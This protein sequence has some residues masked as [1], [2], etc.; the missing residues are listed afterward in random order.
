MD[1][2]PSVDDDPPY[3]HPDRSIE[4]RL[5]DLLSR[6][7]PAEKVGQ[8]VGT[9]PTL[10]PD[11]ETVDGIAEAVTEHHLGAVSPFG[12]GGSPWETPE[13]CL[14]IANAIQREAVENTRLGI[15]V[16]LYVDA[17]HG[18]GF[19]KGATVFPHNLGMAAT[20]DPELI[21]RAA[22]VTA[23]EVA[24]TGAHQNLNPV[25]DVGREARWGRIYETFGESP[26][27]CSAMSAAAVRGYQGED[28]GDAGSVIA[29]PKHFPA[30]SQPVRG[31]DG[32]PVDVSEYTLRR[33]FRPPFAAAVDAGAGSIMP[34]YNELNGYPVHG[35]REYLTG[36]LREE[37]GFSGYVVSDWNGVNMLHHDHRTARSMDEAVWQAA[38]AGVDVAS[39]GGVEH[40]QRLLNLFEAGE[41]SE[42]R[43]D[44]S[45]RRVLEAKFRLGLFEDPYV[46]EDRVEGV[47]TDDHRAVAREA[48]RESLTLLQNDDDVLPLD[49]D[50]D[51]I[52]VLG[53]NADD[54]RNQFGGWSTISEPEPPGTT[55]RE[56]IEAAVPSDTDVRY[57]QGTEMT[58]PIDVD[59]AREAATVS[60]AA[61]VVVGETG[62][63]HEF[64]RSETDRGEFPTRSQLELPEAQR[65]LL[66]AVRKTG[67]PTVA[68]F[69]AGRPLAMEWTAD[70]VPA[71][72]FAYL[73][74]S[75]GGNAVADVLFG[76]VDPGGS[77]PVSIP[78]S[79]GHL[80]THFDY[81]PHPHPIEGSPREE[82]P[83]PPEHPETYDP[84]FPFGHGLSYTD[85]ET[86]ELA[87][88]P[89]RVGREG[90]LTAT[91]EVENVGD[92]PGSTAIHL[93]ATDEFSSRVTPVRE[94]VGFRRVELAVGE[95][96]EVTFEVE[97]ADLGV[98]AESG[99]RRAEPGTITL[100]CC[101]DSAE[102]TIE[103]QFE[104]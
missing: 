71:I 78:R 41:L 72:L 4:T 96:T 21:E 62:Y 40:A 43:I 79:T 18:H 24:A 84:L 87:A 94:L 11:R 54:L 77:L 91:V 61:V 50:L 64:H 12:H 93:Y 99:D 58:E 17:D 16:L 76:D 80:P 102:V 86:G 47:G 53:P 98:V 55:V 5:D 23:T 19:V 3:K 2:N 73:P 100:S 7:T 52:A 14:D 44:E 34:A 67:T 82:N 65:E 103:R 56:G 38:T 6:M 81:R 63:R 95:R 45:V 70:H 25:A 68:V 92:R 36:W 97:I 39:V 83:R 66:A 31:E 28:V 57:E 10:R 85:F 90:R 88:S 35:S 15:P 48:A 59:A 69:V 27:L 75:E 89:E 60:E 74:G 29:T 1:E 30:Y 26:H 51:S 104:S 22:N 46:D 49:T 32:S 33:V 20:R 42:S 101:G 37:L 8:L 9:A 13:E